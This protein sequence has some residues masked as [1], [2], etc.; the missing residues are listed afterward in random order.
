MPLPE[1][2]LGNAEYNRRDKDYEGYDYAYEILSV[3]QIDKAIPMAELRAQYGL[4]SA[5]RGLIY[6]PDLMTN[7]I[8]WRKGKELLGSRKSVEK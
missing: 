3:Y 2:G 1:N 7:T 8:A 4:K 6:T 5:P